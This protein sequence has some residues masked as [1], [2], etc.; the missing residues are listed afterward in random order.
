MITIDLNNLNLPRGACILDI[1]CGNGRHTAAAYDRHDTFVVGADPNHDDLIEAG[2]RLNYHHQL[3]GPSSSRWQL[4][5]ADVT[6]LPFGDAS[7][8]LVICSEVLEHIPD[9][10]R[11]IGELNRVIRPGG[12]LA[13]SVPRRWP[14]T[15]CWVLSA[16]YRTTPGGHLRI[17]A[18]RHLRNLIRNTGLVQWRT[19]Y[20]HGLHS[21]YWWLKC[22]LG[23]NR[24]HLYPVR[25]FH[26]FLTW[27]MMTKPTLTRLLDRWLNPVCGKS[28]VMYFRKPA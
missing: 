21:P 14:E 7:F 11:A 8:D 27:D 10:K 16:D 15:I 23:V 6:A 9:H 22:I 26:R 5:S 20:A 17:Y 1:G 13:V 28:V 24:D 12:Q 25:Q 18:P 2:K 3:G 19:H 4:A